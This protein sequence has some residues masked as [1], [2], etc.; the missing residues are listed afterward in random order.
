MR[1]IY[2]IAIL[3]FVFLTAINCLGQITP[4]Q[5][6][7]RRQ[8]SDVRFSPDGERIAF[9]V[10]EPPKGNSRLTHIWI[11]YVRTHELRQFTASTKSETSPRWSP[12]GKRL[13]FIS[14]REDTPQIYLIPIDGG[15]AI[16]LT[17]GKN[18]IQSFEWS[19]DG[20]QI[21]FLAQEP[22]TD[23]EEKKERDKDDAH[24]I[25]KSEKHAR[26]WIIDVATKKVRQLTSGPWAVS[27]PKWLPQGDRLIALATDHPEL[28]LNTERIFSIGTADGKMKEIAAPKGPFGNL[29]VS[30]DG[31]WFTFSGSRVDG[32]SPH[33]LYLE[34]MDGGA[35]R[36]LTASGIDRPIEEVV[37]R[38]DGSIVAV[39]QNGFK[40]GFY[41]IFPNGA[42][43]PMAAFEVN[44]SSFALSRS[45]V[46]AF[47][48]QT[49]TDAPEL[50]LSNGKGSAEKV[51]KFND[52]WKKI[53]VIKPE[54][55]RYK[56]FDGTE[57]E[58]ALL[59]PAGY[60][61]GTKVPTVFLI[62][63][64]PTG[65]WS[66]NFESWGQLLAARGYAI[67]Y[68]NIRGSVGY[69]HK[70]I[71]SNRG[72]WGGGDFK[73][74]MAGVDFLV[75][76]G[77]A[78]PE[79]L[80]IGGWSYGGYMSEWAITQTN[81]FKAAITGAGL[82][83]L[84]SEFGTENGSSYDEWFY[85]TPYEKP[86]G[87]AKS[88]PINYIKNAHTPTLILQGDADVTDPIGQ[89]QQLYRGLKRYGVESDF[90]VYP[91][92]GHGFREEK[93]LIDR[94]NRIINWYDAH[95]K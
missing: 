43:E 38:Q 29:T 88:S 46:L 47:V 52:D 7:N 31:K 86:E 65:R 23:A 77:I 2:R 33:D 83:D 85:G 67:F 28:D 25:D 61:E 34:S 26:L 72:D 74:V 59:K 21:A 19:P 22:K 71:E 39:V 58:G 32:P 93:H 55:L 15:E 5:T 16:K 51:T 54:F 27:D 8:I 84:A 41:E 42:V 95:L 91:R 92:E 78:D 70:F 24:V 11:M 62:H 13:A 79:R 44:P 76:R 4:E 18:G 3:L 69:G 10:T 35:P 75:A 50:R 63:G 89:S 57:I 81:R 36:N 37:W 6:L 12:D 48:G 66:D 40:S 45:G 68:P 82:A 73:D 20:S 80:G 49:T 56:S 53:A 64:G 60:K 9:T 14:G 30:P 87:F 90:V 94:L 1:F 17:E